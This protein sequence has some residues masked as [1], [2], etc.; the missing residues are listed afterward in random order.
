WKEEGLATK[1]GNNYVAEVTHFT[2][3]NY[4]FPIN[5]VN[6]CFSLS[7]TNTL[8]DFYFEI[9]RNETN[10]IVYAGYTNDVGQ[11]CGLFPKDEN[12][13]LQVYGSCSNEVIY[14]QNIG[15]YS[16]DFTTTYNLSLP[17]EY[18]ET[19]ITANVTDCDGNTLANGYAVLGNDSTTAT[20][21][22]SIIN[23]EINYALVYCTANNYYIKVYDADADVNSEAINLSLITPETSL[24]TLSA[25][26]NVTYEIGDLVA[27]GAVFY[28]APTPTDLDGDGIVDIGLVCDLSDYDTTVKWGCVF[29]DLPNVPNVQYNNGSPAGAGAEIGDGMS[30]TNAIL[31][32]CPDAPAALAARSLG[33]D[34]YLPSAKE[35][36]EIYDNKTALE[37]ATGFN[38]L[39]DGYWSSSERGGLGAWFQIFING[40]QDDYN[41]DI[42]GGSVRAIRTF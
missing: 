9:V 35:L 4:D 32:D 27:G 42:E 17:N 21:V 37:N 18:A 28:I 22:V 15:L 10:Q 26:G 11:T 24:G 8:T 14:T 6:A 39:S 12:L 2:W 29:T 7:A 34:W 40:V 31:S 41:K 3:W 13:T 33:A 38:A 16:D 36:N 20:E 23:G 25:C 5:T 19:T 30:N 1:V